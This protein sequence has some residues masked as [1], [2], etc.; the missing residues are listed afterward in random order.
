[1]TRIFKEKNLVMPVRI[2]ILASGSS[3]NCAYVATGTT[4]LLIDAGLSAKETRRRMEQIGAPL[5]KISAICVTHE[6]SDHIAGLRVLQKQYG[7]PVYVNA[8]TLEALRQ[9]KDAEAVQFRV[10]TSG[11]PFAVGDI[12]IAP[13][14]VPH[15]AFEP[16][17]FVLELNGFRVGFATDIGV[18]TTLVRERLKGARLLVLEANHDEQMV[19]DAKRPWHLKQRILGRQGHLSNTRAAEMLVEVAGDALRQVFLAH[20]SRDCNRPEI[21]MRT[22]R[23]ALDRAGWAHV[24]VS[25]TYADQISEIWEE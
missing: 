12:Q 15:D 11:Q 13:F 5:E 18:P 4:A 17:G 10:F 20:L 8:G 2:C 24:R 3:G 1:M 9:Q 16:V 14:S 6:H 25:P 7:M 19:Q 22:V 23:A 21:A